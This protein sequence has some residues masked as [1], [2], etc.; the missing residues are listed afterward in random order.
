ME[1][2]FV[3]GKILQDVILD[4]DLEFT[5]NNFCFSAREKTLVSNFFTEPGGGAVNVG[6]SLKKLGFE[7]QVLGVVGKDSV[8]DYIRREFKKR[9]LET[10]NIGASRVSSGNSIIILTKNKAHTAL[11]YPG[12]NAELKVDDFEWNKIKKCR[13]W[14]IMSWGN[15]DSKIVD[16][17]IRHKEKLGNHLAFNPGKIQLNNLSLVKKILEITDILFVNEAELAAILNHKIN[18][19]HKKALAEVVGMGPKIVVLTLGAAGSLVYNGFKFYQAP[20]YPVSQ[21]DAL[22]AGDAYSSA[23][24][25]WFIKTG[26]IEDA[27]KAATFNSGSVVEGVGALSGQLAA[28]KIKEMINK[29]DLKIVEEE[30]NL[31]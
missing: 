22:G 12:A 26:K 31:D 23:F 2:I 17:I 11:I 1:K 20:I 16:S 5:N 13:W 30:Y 24:L 10:A 14:Y 18:Q 28:K 25:A 8:G 4:T 9:G 15:N 19:D 6:F 21:S 3:L 27:I 29:I 7:P